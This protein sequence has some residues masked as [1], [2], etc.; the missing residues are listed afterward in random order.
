M[1]KKKA[2]HSIGFAK[3]KSIIIRAIPYVV[4]G[5][6]STNFG[7]AWR[8]SEGQDISKRFLSF[9]LKLPEA[10]Q[11]FLPTFHPLDLL[12]LSLIHI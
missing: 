9:I 10:F 6:L 11:N 1:N 7:E 5:L 3:A 12:V 4:V 8:L 2:S